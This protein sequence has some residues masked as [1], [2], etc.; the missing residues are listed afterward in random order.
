VV[1]ITPEKTKALIKQSKKQKQVL[2][3][4]AILQ[5]AL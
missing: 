4:L 1:A 2:P 3:L 5:T